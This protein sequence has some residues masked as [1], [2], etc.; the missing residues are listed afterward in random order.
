MHAIYTTGSTV[1]L[2]DLRKI[3][4]FAEKHGHKVRQH[5][6]VPKRKGIIKEALWTLLEFCGNSVF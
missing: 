1:E 2:Q 5:L 6:N 3:E 4:K